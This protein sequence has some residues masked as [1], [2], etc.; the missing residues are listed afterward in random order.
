MQ[1]LNPFTLYDVICREESGNLFGTVPHTARDLAGP[2][3]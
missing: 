1:I 2:I 3:A